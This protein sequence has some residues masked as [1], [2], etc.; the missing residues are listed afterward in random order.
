MKR[1]LADLPSLLLSITKHIFVLRS[2]DLWFKILT[3]VGHVPFKFA[4][5]VILH[6]LL[7]YAV[8]S[9]SSVRSE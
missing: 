8:R 1:L 4:I 9:F 7:F 3:T 6:L 2:L 5:I